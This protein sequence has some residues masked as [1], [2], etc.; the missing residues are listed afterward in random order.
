MDSFVTF[1][2]CRRCWI[3]LAASGTVA[4]FEVYN[5][6]YHL[7]MVAWR[8]RLVQLV[9]ISSL[10]SSSMTLMSAESSA[11]SDSAMRTSSSPFS[12]HAAL[13][14]PTHV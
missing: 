14:L 13:R 4:A 2:R 11:R 5:I 9:G 7:A 12:A 6:Y 1:S 10:S 8:H 3:L